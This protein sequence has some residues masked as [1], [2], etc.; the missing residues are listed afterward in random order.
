MKAI[1]ISGGQDIDL[2]RLKDETQRGD[3][4]ICADSGFSYLL[5]I[6]VEPDYIVG[7]FDSLDKT[8]FKALKQTKAEIVKYKAEKNETDHEIAITKA[9][10]LGCD[11]FVLFGILGSRL[12]HSLGNIMNMGKLSEKGYRVRAYGKENDIIWATKGRYKISTDK[13]YISVIAMEK[14]GVTYS[15]TGCKYEVSHLSIAYGSTRGVSNEPL[16]NPVY[17][18]VE[19]GEGVIICSRNQ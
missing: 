15:T 6:D 1:I 4:V 8:N 2:E 16:K 11:E 10:E 19:Q 7:D 3:L 18:D 12:D 5:S 14:E 17:I 13:Y 9:L